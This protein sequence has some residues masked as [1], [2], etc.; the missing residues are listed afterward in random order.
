MI[1]QMLK[2][3]WK[4]KRANGFLVAEI[5]LTYFVLF[6]VTTVILDALDRYR[7]PNGFSTEN[8]LN[9]SMEEIGPRS[10]PRELAPVF[11]RLGRELRDLDGVAEVGYTWWPLY[12]MIMNIGTFDLGDG[13][14]LQ[15]NETRLSDACREVL[16]LELVSGRWFGPEDDGAQDTPAVINE[17]LARAL[18]GNEDPLGRTFR[19][20]YRVIGV[21]TD[22]R[23]Y[24]EFDDPRNLL[25]T[26]VVLEPP[27][28]ETNPTYVAVILLKTSRPITAELN[29][30][31]LETLQAVEPSW[32]YDITPV[33]DMRVSMLK[34][35]ITPYLMAGAAGTSLVGMVVLGLFGVLWQNIAARTR[36]IGLRRAKGATVRHIY[37]QITGEM[38]IV[39]TA[40][41]IPGIVLVLQMIAIDAAGSANIPF[42]VHLA[43]IALAAVVL[44]VIVILCSLYPGYMATRINPAEAL[45]YE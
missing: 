6:A 32:T 13:R 23:L 34:H 16:E 33:E 31:I 43:A 20:R 42:S 7:R 22:F 30:S 19:E 44:Y 10:E 17:N 35:R 25:I 28:A 4:R 40:G 45:R 24:G 11:I 37:L 26:R 5:L 38:L 41:I 36:E 29:A 18:F 14:K 21:I 1:R 3:I 12:Q 8:L 2:L 39:A 15:M 27:D 9:I